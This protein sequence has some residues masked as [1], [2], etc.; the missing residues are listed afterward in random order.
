MSQ[1]CSK[2]IVTLLTES[3]A[4]AA[5]N[6]RALDTLKPGSENITDGNIYSLKNSWCATDI[7]LLRSYEYIG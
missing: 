7:V 2:V 1:P 6:N 5:L 3:T 4:S